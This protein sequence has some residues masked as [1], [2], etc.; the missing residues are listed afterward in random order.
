M[1]NGEQNFDPR[2]TSQGGSE[3]SRQSIREF[4]GRAQDYRGRHSGPYGNLIQSAAPTA[5]RLGL[6]TLI[7]V[8]ASRG[9]TDPALFNQQ[10]ADI[11]R[12]TQGQQQAIQ[13]Q[14]AQAGLQGSGVMA[15][16]QAAAGQAGEDRIAQAKAQENAMAEERRRQDLDLLMRMIMDPS[17]ELFGIHQNVEQAEKQRTLQRDAALANAIGGLFG[18]I[19]GGIGGGGGGGQIP[20]QDLPYEG[21]GNQ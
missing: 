6:S 1:A 14:G 12:G 11:Q 2:F 16:L 5:G 15:A 13:Q 10:V 20:S 4:L 21:S 8:L 9:R 17:M 19:F 18:S 3:Q 7:D